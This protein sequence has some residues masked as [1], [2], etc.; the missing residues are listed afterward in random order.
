M[1]VSP[2]TLNR[3]SVYLRCFRQ[4]YQDGIPRISSQGL[5]QN[6]H[7]SATQI[8]KD[9]A[10]F[11]E[12]GIR[13]VGYEVGPLVRRLTGVLG[14]DQIHSLAVVGMGSLGSAIVRH[15]GAGEGPFGV[16]AGFDNDPRKIGHRHGDVVIEPASAIGTVVPERDIKIGV[17]AVPA[18]AAQGV[19]DQLVAAGIR[20]VLNFAPARLHKTEGVHSRNVDL[21]IYLEELVFYQGGPRP[22]PGRS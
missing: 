7:L 9:L 13:G 19:Y 4:L 22:T 1:D 16:T 6:F 3:L 2:L 20:S 15:V 10:Q 21:G 5:A 11:G 14:L 17:L 12:F 8:R 18:S